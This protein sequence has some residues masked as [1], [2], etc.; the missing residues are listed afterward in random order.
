VHALRAPASRSHDELDSRASR[1][2]QLH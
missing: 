1:C 2:D